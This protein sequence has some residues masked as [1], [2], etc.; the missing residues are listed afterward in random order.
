[1]TQA[2]KKIKEEGLI[3][4]R[5]LDL[6]VNLHPSRVFQDFLLWLSKTLPGD[7]VHYSDD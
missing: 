1:M 2:H 7:L 5:Y 6:D 3:Q 4:A